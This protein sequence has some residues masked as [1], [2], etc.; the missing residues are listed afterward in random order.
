VIISTV[1]QGLADA[2]DT[3]T[4]L[5]CLAYAPDSV[6]EPCFYV[7]EVAVEFDAAFGRGMDDIDF[8]CM[9]LVSR[10][11]DK[12]SQ[13]K[14]DGYLSGSGASSVKVALEAAPTLGGACDDLHVKRIQGYRWYTH[15]D[16][17]YLGAE[18][19]VRVIGDGA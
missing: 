9:V 15:G 12:A 16:A 5:N 6:P 4:G 19:V 8:T 1:R 10:A 13:A 7:S 11:D 18:F 17:K 2:A 14:L 3:I